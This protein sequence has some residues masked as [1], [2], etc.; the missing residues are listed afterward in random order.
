[1]NDTKELKRWLTPK[2]VANEYGISIN[3]QAKYRMRSVI[4]YSKI[5]RIIRYDRLKLDEWFEKHAIKSERI[6]P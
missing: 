4:P 1:M 3:T 6:L 2:D 5:N